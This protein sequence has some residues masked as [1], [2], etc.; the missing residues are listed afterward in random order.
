MF[1]DLKKANLISR[2]TIFCGGYGSGKSEIAV[3]YALAMSRYKQNI[4]IADLDV[5]NPYFRS[6]EARAVLEQHGIEVISPSGKLSTADL[7]ALP[8][9]I[10]RVL[11]SQSI[12][13]MIDVGG[14]EVGA[15]ALG[16]FAEHVSEDNK[17]FLVVNPARPFQ[18]SAQNIYAL[19]Q[20]I[21]DTAKL[22]INGIIN[23]TNLIYETTNQFI[24]DAYPIVEETAR[25]LE[26]PIV[27]TTVDKN[28]VEIEGLPKIDTEFF[29]LDM[30]LSP[31]WR[32]K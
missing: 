11:R 31:K 13:A 12:Y 15:R 1:I 8:A 4:A 25:L 28:K 26:V 21:M 7:P 3:N 23:N 5:V 27:F 16:R 6:R 24:E 32:K 2:V 22:K 30:Q 20:K 10:Y 9:D 17:M 19:A 29:S 18:N 14:D